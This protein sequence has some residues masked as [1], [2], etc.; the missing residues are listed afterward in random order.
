M[1][2]PHPRDRVG[3]RPASSGNSGNNVSSMHSHGPSRGMPSPVLHGWRAGSFSSS[4]CS[5]IRI[6]A[7]VVA[8]VAVA[9]AAAADADAAAAAAAAATDAAAV[10]GV[11]T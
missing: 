5:E 3:H 7:V 10:A 8:V 9:P 11:G 4:S 6:A 1:N 2:Q